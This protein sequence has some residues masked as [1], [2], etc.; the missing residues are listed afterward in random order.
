M[1]INYK[2]YVLANVSSTTTL[3]NPV[4]SG[5]QSTATGFIICNTNANTVTAT[6]TLTT[7]GKT[8]NLIKN[9]SILTG[10]SLNIIDAGRLILGQNDSISVNA[11]A[12][13]DVI[14]SVIEVI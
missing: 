10:T 4:N 11:S 5:I 12:N 13:V 2:N 1:S 9:G 8:V 6:A 7:S 14:L 3:Y